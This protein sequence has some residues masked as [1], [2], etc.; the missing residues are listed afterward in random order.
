MFVSQPEARTASCVGSALPEPLAV[1]TMGTA[2]C[3][4]LFPHNLKRWGGE[5]EGRGGGGWWSA[6]IKGIRRHRS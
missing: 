6:Q 1:E 3:L 2:P 4:W 5:S